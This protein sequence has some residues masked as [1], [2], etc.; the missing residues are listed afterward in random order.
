MLNKEELKKM[1]K[2]N[3]RVGSAWELKVRKDLEKQ[4]WLDKQ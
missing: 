2:K 3:K 1:G 4:D